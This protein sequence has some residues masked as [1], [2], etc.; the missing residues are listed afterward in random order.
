[1][2]ILVM[3]P[4]LFL[5]L[6]SKSCEDKTSAEI[7]ACIQT[8]ISEYAHRSIQN[9]SG[10]FFEYEYH[11]KKVYLFEP[12]CCD[13]ISKLYDSECNLLCTAGGFAGK[14]DSLC[15]DF[16]Q[17]RSNEKLIWEDLKQKQPEPGK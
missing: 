10:K 5:L 9:P 14:V 7:P 17:T 2:K 3:V 8:M 4:V 16:Y 11:G 13:Q 12:P 1:M 15:R 6:E